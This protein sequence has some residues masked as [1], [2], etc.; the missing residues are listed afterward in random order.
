M[1]SFPLLCA[2]SLIALPLACLLSLR[3][4]RKLPPG[5]YPLPII[6]NLLHV[7]RKPYES[8]AQLSKKHG[9]LM[10][11]RLGS[12]YSVV[13]SSPE[14]AKEILQKHGG[15]FSGRAT[16]DS[17][18]VH[19]HGKVSMALLPT[20]ST[21][22]DLRKICKEEMF[23]H[24]SLEG[25]EGLR[26]EKLQKLLDY[27][28]ECCDSG[29]AV[30]L[31][32]ASFRTTYELMSATVF[33]TQGTDHFD[34]G[35]SREFMEMLDRIVNV[36]TNFADFFPFL[37][38]FDP[39]GVKRRVEIC[40]GKMLDKIERYVDQRMQSR[41]TNAKTK[42]KSDF[43]DAILDKMEGNEYPLITT[44]HLT[45]LMLVRSIDFQFI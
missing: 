39:Q 24:H 22:R 30:D 44:R 45:H 13:V 4:R 38:P 18:L 29:Q 27:V 7:G 35:D 42:T 20:D 21:W 26:R 34:P 33:S 16:C 8:L 19:D 37:K 10:S 41:K 36:E 2:L 17:F 15:V 6:G 25:S 12:V 14:M 5:P 43:L 28:Q 1:D 11:I 9:P 32:E 31:R 3:R 40:F 23:V